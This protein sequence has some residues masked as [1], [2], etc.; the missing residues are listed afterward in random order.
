M[1]LTDITDRFPRNLHRFDSENERKSLAEASH[2]Y[3]Q[4]AV[5]LIDPDHGLILDANPAMERL[6]GWRISDLV[7]RHFDILRGD[8]THT[9][10]KIRAEGP[11]FV[12]QVMRHHDGHNVYIDLM[13]AIVPFD[14]GK[15]I[16]AN[17]RQ[18]D[19]RAEQ[20]QRTREM[21]D[22]HHLLVREMNHRVKSHLHTISSLLRT[23]A[24]NVA[25]PDA[26][27]SLM[28]CSGQIR[29]IGLLHSELSTR[30]DDLTLD[31]GQYIRRLV[32]YV[33]EAAGGENTAAQIDIDIAPMPLLPQQATPAALLIFEML[34]NALRHAWPGGMPNGKISITG[35]IDNARHACLE[36]ADDG[37]GFDKSTPPGLG[38][39]LIEALAAQL[40]ADISKS[41]PPGTKYSICWNLNDDGKDNG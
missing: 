31:L 6:F 10:E 9:L 36:I 16:I 37:I 12:E 19:E 7:G 29:A 24:R 8:D 28:S 41:G 39:E 22:A 13:A 18:A 2:H 3:T 26:R 27:R 32:P 34:N 15:A 4:D 25:T 40:S 21:L 20:S 1:A 33:I 38:L 11:V 17:L 14:N 23:R 5:L 35:G 30:T